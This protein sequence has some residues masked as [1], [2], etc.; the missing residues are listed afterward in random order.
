[1]PTMTWSSYFFVG[2]ETL[3]VQHRRLFDIMDELDVA[4]KD[5]QAGGVAGRLL[6][7][8]LEYTRV[9]FSTEETMMRTAK[10]AGFARHRDLHTELAGQVKEYLAR[11][12]SGDSS[13]Q[14]ELL[15]FLR[16][17]LADHIQ[18][19]DRAFGVWLNAHGVS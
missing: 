14:A 6:D 19:E 12:R 8:L 18:R 13:V 15:H 4:M 9:H 11:E 5:G 2:V 16:E 17:W 1:M 3:D 7:E 10:Y